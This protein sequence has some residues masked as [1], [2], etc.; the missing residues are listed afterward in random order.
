[1]RHHRPR[2]HRLPRLRLLQ[3]TPSPQRRRSRR[4][5]RKAPFQRF[6][7]ESPDWSASRGFLSASAEALRLNGSHRCSNHRSHGMT[8]SHLRCNPARGSNPPG[9]S[10]FRSRTHRSIC[11]CACRSGHSSH[12]DSPHSDS[13]RARRGLISARSAVI[14]LAPQAL[15]AATQQADWAAMV[16]ANPSTRRRVDSLHRR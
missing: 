2:P 4:V 15:Q 1:V 8:C 9:R 11:A 7:F 13:S 12:R 10:N 16:V 14:A 6:I 3:R 5:G